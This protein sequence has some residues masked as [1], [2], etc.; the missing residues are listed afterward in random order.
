MIFL[1]DL[2]EK[3]APYMLEWMHDAELAKCFQRDMLGMSLQ[4]AKNFCN[5]SSQK[6]KLED[7][8]D[9]H[10][11]ITDEKDEYLGTISLKNINQKNGTA[12][13]AISI[14]RHAQGMG[15]AREATRLLLKK[16]FQDYGL[17][18]IYLNVL[19]DNVRAVKFYEKCGFVYEGEF[20]EHLKIEGRLKSLKWFGI[21]ENEFNMQENLSGGGNNPSIG[22]LFG[23]Y[24]LCERGTYSKEVA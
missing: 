7:S 18:R 20:R 6:S 4:D 3:D 9:L 12:E 21:L 19:S 14:R 2:E 5:L 8:Q 1:R 17:H 13:Y 24:V 22:Y 11:A 10:Y 16:G 15:V 23:S